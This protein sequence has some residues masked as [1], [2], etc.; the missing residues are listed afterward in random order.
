[1]GAGADSDHT[2]IRP[3]TPQYI[4]MFTTLCRG[5]FL[6]L[7]LT[8][9]IGPPKKDTLD[10]KYSH[11]QPQFFVKFITRAPWSKIW[12]FF[13]RCIVDSASGVKNGPFVVEFRPRSFYC[14]C[15]SRN[16]TPGSKI[17][18]K[19]VVRP[20]GE[21]LHMELTSCA[22]KTPKVGVFRWQTK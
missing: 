7:T 13:S 20:R 2:W 5:H 15:M 21:H 18:Q 14:A 22:D 9:V 4:V 17:T 16:R 3:C 12:P 6:V 19:S 8:I 1:M 10:P 11:F